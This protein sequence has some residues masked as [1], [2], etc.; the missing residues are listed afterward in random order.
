MGDSE[1]VVEKRRYCTVGCQP[2]NLCLLTTIGVTV[3]ATSLLSVSIFTDF[4]EKVH[5]NASRIEDVVRL[6]NGSH[7]LTWLFNQTVR[8]G[9]NN[10]FICFASVSLGFLSSRAL[11]QWLK[12]G[13]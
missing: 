8:F 7:R 1:M 2:S 3:L 12:L 4:W 6:H 10:H 9:I 11:F 5:Y 13:E